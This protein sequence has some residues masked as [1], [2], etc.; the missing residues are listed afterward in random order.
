MK[1]KLRYYCFSHPGRVRS[2]NQDNFICEG[3][4][5]PEKN[6][7]T[8][9]V[10]SGLAYSSDKPVFGVFDGMGGHSNGEKAAFIAASVIGELSLKRRFDPV[11]AL[12]KADSTIWNSDPEHV[13]RS[14]GTTAVLAAPLRRTMRLANIG[15]SKIYR[16]S[17]GT[18][19]QLSQ[20]HLM[21]GAFSSKPSLYQYLGMDPEE[22]FIEP[23]YSETPLKKGDV[24]V[25][26][27]DGI[28]DMVEM[29]EI[30]AILSDSQQDEACQRVADRAM[31]HG[32]QDN[33]TI[34]L[35]YVE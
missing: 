19:C 27:S 29:Q 9:M 8:G 18:I 34:M 17:E 4:I 28:S 14:M 13:G 33:L 6:C 22:S 31:E 35:I 16:Y 12:K 5:M 21:Q 30:A 25:L 7:G 1:S 32:G 26:C 24:Y 20:D 2:N 10:V 3:R 11:A 23:F 15:D